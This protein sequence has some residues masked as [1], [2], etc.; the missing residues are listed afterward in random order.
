MQEQLP[1]ATE[2]TKKPKTW[3]SDWRMFATVAATFVAAKLLG[4]AAALVAVLLFLWLQ[5]KR[6]TWQALAAAVVVG[7]SISVALSFA[8]LAKH[9]APAEQPVSQSPVQPDV[10]APGEKRAA[11]PDWERGVMTPPSNTK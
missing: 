5:P 1:T 7:V 11:E 10:S 6:G 4:V 2:S 3:Y 8:I 9:N